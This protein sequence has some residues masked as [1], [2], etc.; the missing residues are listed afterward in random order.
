MICFDCT[1]ELLAPPDLYF[2]S[3]EGIYLGSKKGLARLIK[4]ATGIPEAALLGR[5]LAS[6]S[7]EQRLSW[8]WN[9]KT[10]RVEDQAYCLTGLF[11]IFMPIMYG[12]E[13]H[14]MTRLNKEIQEKHGK[15]VTLPASDSSPVVS[16]APPQSTV[17]VP[18]YAT[19]VDKTAAIQMDSRSRMPS[20]PPRM[21][22]GRSFGFLGQ[23]SRGI[24]SFTQPSG[25]IEINIHTSR[26]GSPVLIS[27]FR[28]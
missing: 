23:S 17:R 21:Q 1:Q 12:E 8:S 7:I 20:V 10:T 14:A 9:R 24:D 13:E 26:S 16:R 18:S 19:V 28:M 27:E 15:Q 2:F 11:D 25:F 4:E 6:F 5:P 3:K 22:P